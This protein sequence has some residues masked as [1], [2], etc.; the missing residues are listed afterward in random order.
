MGLKFL[1]HPKLISNDGRDVLPE[2]VVRG[3]HLTQPQTIERAKAL[4]TEINGQNL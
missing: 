1:R 2:V 3:L 4:P